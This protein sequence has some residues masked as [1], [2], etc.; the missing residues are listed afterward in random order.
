MSILFY[1]PFESNLLFDARKAVQFLILKMDIF[2]FS[3]ND[4]KID[5]VVFKFTQEQNLSSIKK[6]RDMEFV[7]ELT[8]NLNDL[9]VFSC[10][11]IIHC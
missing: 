5:K 2:L 11:S 8:I 4:T 10:G 1:I 9:A 6:I 3:P 7:S